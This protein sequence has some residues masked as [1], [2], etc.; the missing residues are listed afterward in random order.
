MTYYNIISY[1]QYQ[2]STLKYVPLKL[3]F[4][5][6]TRYHIFNANVHRKI[7]I[8]FLSWYFCHKI[9]NEC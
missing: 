3:N 4:K 9:K 5:Q 6:C 1:L 2:F 8:V 7:L